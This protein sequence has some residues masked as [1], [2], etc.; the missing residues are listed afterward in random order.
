MSLAGG[1]AE[2]QP[3]RTLYLQTSTGGYRATIDSHF[4]VVFG[5]NEPDVHV[6]VGASDQSVSREH[7]SVRTDGTGWILRNHGRLPLLLPGSRQ[8]LKEHEHR[9]PDGYT[10]VFIRT[11]RHSAH[12]IEVLVTARPTQVSTSRPE[13]PTVHDRVAL[14]RTERRLLVVLSQHYLRG[15]DHPQPRSWKEVAEELNELDGGSSWTASRAAHVVERIRTRAASSGVPGITQAEGLRASDNTI[16]HNLITGLLMS[17]T[18]V[19]PD[20][21]E[22]GEATDW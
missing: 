21:R 2:G 7:G 19:P 15:D 3:P 18:L 20:L 9:L 14:D 12:L 5:R 4:T 10:P 16:K 8:L 13:A 11:G 17:G 6:C 1:V 22:I